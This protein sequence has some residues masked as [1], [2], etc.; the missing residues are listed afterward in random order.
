MPAIPKKSS[1]VILTRANPDNGF[2]VLLLKRNDNSKFMGGNYVYPGG[3]VDAEDSDENLISAGM[4]LFPLKSSILFEDLLSVEE[5]LAYRV[6]AIRELFEEAGILLAYKENG[7]LFC[8]EDNDEKK[9]FNE[10]RSSLYGG[11]IRFAEMLNKEKL[12]PA[13]DRLS[14]FAHWL[15]PEISPVRFI[16]RFFIANLP[17]GQEAIH[18][19]M[20]IIH[21][22]WLSAREALSENLKGN[23]FLSP[24]TL[25]T[26]EEIS[27]YNTTEELFDSLKDQ[28]IKQVLPVNIKVNGVNIIVFPCDPEY[29]IFKEG[30]IPDAFNHGRRV[31]LEGYTTRVVFTDGRW[32]PYNRAD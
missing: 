23:V 11:G 16:A 7:A 31:A 24:P 19:D 14:Y 13:F 32:L 27:Y 8:P 22:V 9:R 21:S 28:D 20:E 26:L 2:E 10:Y 17:E 12:T 18:D 6:A 4:A 29:K 25:K 15:T 30:K 3:K 5:C 1:T